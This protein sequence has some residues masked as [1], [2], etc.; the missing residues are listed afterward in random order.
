MAR[1]LVP[2][3]AVRCLARRPVKKRPTISMALCAAASHAS[4]FGF[5]S[6][7]GD[8]PS[9]RARA[10][11]SAREHATAETGGATD[12]IDAH[13]TPHAPARDSNDNAGAAGPEPK[14]ENKLYYRR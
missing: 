5:T 2:K 10:Q 7:A 8:P 13:H 6:D 12:A 4:I 11:Q 1:P 9:T 14:N 3:Q